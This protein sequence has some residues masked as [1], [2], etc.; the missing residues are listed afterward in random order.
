MISLTCSITSV[1]S[2]LQKDGFLAIVGNDTSPDSLLYTSVSEEDLAKRFSGAV[3][4]ED[5]LA[6]RYLSCQRSDTPIVQKRI[7]D[8]IKRDLETFAVLNHWSLNDVEILLKTSFRL[9]H[10]KASIVCR[11]P[12]ALFGGYYIIFVSLNENKNEARCDFLQRFC[13]ALYVVCP[14]LKKKFPEP[15]ENNDWMRV[16]SSLKDKACNIAGFRQYKDIFQNVVEQFTDN[17]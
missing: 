6:R 7:N 16:L 5:I 1:F 17:V 2:L 11:I 8:M 15:T 10:S 4:A 3:S 13:K 14:D 12:G 9:L